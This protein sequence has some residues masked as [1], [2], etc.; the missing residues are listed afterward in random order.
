MRSINRI[1]CAVF[2]L[3][4]LPAVVLF[5]LGANDGLGPDPAQALVRELG[6]WSLRLLLLV[7][8]IS[9]LARFAGLRSL[10]QYRR[11]LGLFT[12]FYASLHLLGYAVLLLEL[13]WQQLG[14]ELVERPYI[15]IG[16]A[17]LLALLPLAMTSTR[18]WQRRLGRNWKRL[19]RLVYLAAVLALMHLLW[20][21]R[22]DYGE[23]ALYTMIFGVLMLLRVERVGALIGRGE[24]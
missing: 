21:V 19:H 15:V 3:C 8:A 2:A 16:A 22:S 23:F 10:L 7:L 12:F 5:Y 1:D 6:Q 18:N 4:L 13:Q 20:Q 11:M 17:A 24:R 9:P 14:S